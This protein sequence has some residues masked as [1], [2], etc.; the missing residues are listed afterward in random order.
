MKTTR[1]YHNCPDDNLMTK[2]IEGKVSEEQEDYILKHLERCEECSEAVKLALELEGLE[3]STTEN[4]KK[5]TEDK[6][7]NFAF[8]G[9]TVGGVASMIDNIVRNAG[10]T[11]MVAAENS[12]NPERN[13]E[14]IDSNYQ[15]L[16]ITEDMEE[17]RIIGEDPIDLNQF[18]VQQTY[19]DTCAIKSQQLILED[20]GLELTEDQLVAEAI[21]QG[22]YH[23]G[24]GTYPQDV[25]KLL[26]THGVPVEVTEN[27]SIIDLTRAL[28]EGHKVI[29]GVDSGELWKDGP[30]EFIEDMVGGEQADHALIVAGIDVAN[31][32]VILTDPGSGEA[33]ARYPLDQ[34]LNAW[35]DSGN[36]MVETT[37]PAPLEYNPEMTGFDY[38][39]GHIDNIG[40]MPY[41][42]FENNILPITEAMSVGFE[43]QSMFFDNFHQMIEGEANSFSSDIISSFGEDSNLSDFDLSESFDPFN[44]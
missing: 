26:E 29:I 13:I 24:G 42:Y 31:N 22:I 37:E 27:G 10:K 3:T 43:H 23:P 30:F 20:F 39:L 35:E 14:D 9:F 15:T 38:E 21:N 19:P 2:F 34:F 36:F 11:S 41:A 1:L 4:S 7:K 25:G 40:S 6:F 16:K 8:G 18:D 17:N 33:G 28:A 5:D 32:E 44:F 12:E